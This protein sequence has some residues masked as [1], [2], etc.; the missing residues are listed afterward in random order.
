MKNVYRIGTW[1]AFLAFGATSAFTVVQILQVIGVLKYP[2][3]EIFIYSTSQC[4]AIPF[5]LAILALHYVTPGD[6]KFFSHAALIFAV[7]YMIFVTANYVVQLTTV[8]PMTLRG[9]ADGIR[10][11]VQTPHSLFWDFDAI[12]YIAMGFCAAFSVPVF[13]KTGLQKWV[14]ISFIVHAATT[15]VIGFV[16]FYPVFSTDLLLLGLPWAFSAP[17]FLLFLALH[18]KAGTKRFG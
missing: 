7:V 2:W 9:E 6:K 3:D 10:V 13:Q 11:L 16:Y 5:V 12:G 8:I 14:R 17:T 15:P 18:F 1:S 4:I